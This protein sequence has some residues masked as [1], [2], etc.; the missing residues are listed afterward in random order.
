M[1]KNITTITRSDLVDLPGKIKSHFEPR[2]KTMEAG[3]QMIIKRLDHME[4]GQKNI[5]H[6]LGR[7][8]KRNSHARKQINKAGKN[9]Q[10]V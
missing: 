2:F 9:L 4:V 6:R 8:E 7:M 3:Q 1:K 10:E 5:I